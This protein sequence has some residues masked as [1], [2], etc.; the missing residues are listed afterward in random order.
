MEEV[1]KGCPMIRMGEW[2]SFFWYRLTRVVPDQRPL[3]GCVCVCVCVCACACVWSGVYE[4]VERLSV[5]LSR[6]VGLLLSAVQAGDINQQRQ[7]QVHR[8]PQQR[9]HNTMLSRRCEQCHVYS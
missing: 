3:N 4:M 5:C 8:C 2:V 7:C 1:D 6:M 9:C